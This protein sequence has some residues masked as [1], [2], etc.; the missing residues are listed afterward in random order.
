MTIVNDNKITP[1]IVT[2][3]CNTCQ[4]EFV[5]PGNGIR[6]DT[7][8]ITRSEHFC[9][10]KC[11]YKSGRERRKTGSTSFVCEVCNKEF[12]KCN[13]TVL[14]HVFC[15]KG[16][17]GIGLSRGITG[18]V[19]V[20]KSPESIEKQKKTK[21][22]M[23]A[24][25]ELIP[26]MIGK[27]HSQETKEKISEHHIKSGCFKGNLNGMFGR[28]HTV[29]ARESMSEK[30]SNLIVAGIRKT[31]GKNN[32]LNGRWHSTKINKEMYYRSSWELACMKW[33]DN[34]PSIFFYEYEGLKIAY[35]YVDEE[36]KYK[37]YY[38][39]DF[40]IT[41]SDGHKELWEIKPK[42]FI[43]NV[44]TLLKTAAAEAWCKENNVDVFC[45][46]TKESLFDLGIL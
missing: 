14:E 37:R 7:R 1:R 44:K 18:D 38:I 39:P 34:N 28:K 9:S 12:R 41:F 27:H 24:S 36:R 22:R 21:K 17:Y 6:L 19:H 26:P 4:T 11:F 46:Y 23:F 45:L 32:H 8:I 20:A 31:Y 33:M 15:S 2:F 42:Q 35:F 13:S 30:H 10:T 43:N 3:S 40:L 25:G 29:S 16:C 5:R